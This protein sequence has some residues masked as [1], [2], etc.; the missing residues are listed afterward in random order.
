MRR[1]VINKQ[2]ENYSKNEHMD[3]SVIYAKLKKK[4]VKLK[5]KILNKWITNSRQKKILMPNN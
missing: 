4:Q 1:N 3:T 2:N 5:I